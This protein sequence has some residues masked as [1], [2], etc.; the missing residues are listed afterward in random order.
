MLPNILDYIYLTL[1]GGVPGVHETP[2]QKIV[3]MHLNEI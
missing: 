1:K 3:S 2:S